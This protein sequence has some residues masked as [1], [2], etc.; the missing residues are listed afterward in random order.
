MAVADST[1]LSL[2]MAHACGRSL[3]FYN[4][5]KSFPRCPRTPNE[6]PAHDRCRRDG[7]GSCHARLLAQ[8]Q[9]ANPAR[10]VAGD[11]AGDQLLF[12]ARGDRHGLV[13]TAAAGK[14]Y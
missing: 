4:A 8:P 2:R 14:P 6:S 5:P 3:T 9:P 13:R 7:L 11:D 10:A 1:Q 12:V